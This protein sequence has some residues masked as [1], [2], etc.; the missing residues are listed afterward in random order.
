MTTIMSII[1]TIFYFVNIQAKLPEYSNIW[2]I[3]EG[4][5]V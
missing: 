5:T 1:A 3:F 4:L 2:A